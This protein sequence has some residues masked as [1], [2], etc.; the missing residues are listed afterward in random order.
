MKDESTKITNDEVTC[1]FPPQQLM[2]GTTLQ[3]GKYKIKKLLGQG[4]FGITYLAEQTA[5]HEDVAIKEFFFKEH[6]VRRIDNSVDL[7][8]PINKDMLIRYLHKFEKEARTISK[9][10][11]PH[12]IAIHDTFNE[13][14]TAYYVMDYVDGESLEDLIRRVGALTDEEANRY[15]KQ[16]ASALSYIHKLNI[17]HLDVKPANIMIR[18]SDNQAILIDFGLS[19]QYD[20]SGG[21]TSTTPVGISHGY[22]P[23]EQ[24]NINGVETFSPQTDIYSLGATLYKMVTGNT[25]PSSL[26][27]SNNGFPQHDY[28]RQSTLN[29]IRY[30][31]EIR[32]ADRIQNV[33]ILLQGDNVLETEWKNN[34][35][36]KLFNI[37][38]T[39]KAMVIWYSI[40]VGPLILSLIY[41]IIYWGNTNNGLFAVYAFAWM[42][43]IFPIW[44]ILFFIFDRIYVRN[45]SKYMTKDTYDTFKWPWTRDLID[46]CPASQ[47]RKKNI[48]ILNRQL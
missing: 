36:S 9:L 34:F 19:K 1:V 31:M 13:N 40:M 47:V 48:P 20:A 2:V 33:D 11:N 3:N 45:V 17:N 25:P 29:N 38:C 27:I 4:G 15:F 46:L 23:I 28:I 21:Q 12:I 41:S 22:A 30:C 5:L 42:M 43:Y 7:S 39:K 14:G 18:R 26:D 35:F 8:N 16:I 6:C 44:V 24:Y 10:D 32:K 37:F